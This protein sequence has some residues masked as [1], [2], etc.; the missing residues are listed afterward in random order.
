MLQK[1]YLQE[2]KSQKEIAR[3]LKCSTNQV[4]YWMGKYGIEMRSI[5]Q[6]I[7]LR[8][9]P[10]GDPFKFVAPNDIEKALLYGLGM[11]LYW[12][13][14]TK[15]NKG[16]VRL[17]NTDARLVKSFMRFLIELFGVKKEDFRFSLQIFSD[18]DKNTATRY[19]VKALDVK[20][21]QFT[22]PTITPYRSI[23]NYRQ[24][25]LYGVITLY[26]HNT[27]LRD[28]IVE[29]LSRIDRTDSK[30]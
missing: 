29:H 19:W 10:D 18:L 2:G 1:L 27:R 9:N 12:G 8:N 23:G 3:K 5:S 28:L 16:S 20:P 26:Y 7:Y 17:G 6:A 21:S 22:K 24:K 4:A 25:S 30:E 14:G 13:E 11:G 15:A